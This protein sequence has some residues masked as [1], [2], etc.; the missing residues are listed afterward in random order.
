MSL[1]KKVVA[2]DE[3]RPGSNLTFFAGFGK[4]IKQLGG[5]HICTTGNEK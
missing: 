2:M 5:V 1:I 3:I 4:E